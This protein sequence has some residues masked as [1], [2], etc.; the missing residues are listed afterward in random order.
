MQKC[1]IFG[2]TKNF[3]QKYLMLNFIQNLNEMSKD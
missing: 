2:E 1:E 3:R